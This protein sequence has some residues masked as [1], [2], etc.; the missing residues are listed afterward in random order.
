MLLAVDSCVAAGMFS[1]LMGAIYNAGTVLACILL[2]AHWRIGVY[3]VLLMM[4]LNWFAHGTADLYPTFLQV[5]RG[6]PLRSLAA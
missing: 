3:A 1:S 5:Q 2:T 4:A 6:F